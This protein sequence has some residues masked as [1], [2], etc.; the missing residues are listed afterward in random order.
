MLSLG[1]ARLID[2]HIR[3]IWSG[4][5]RIAKTRLM[6]VC[7]LMALSQG[8][9]RTANADPVPIKNRRRVTN[10]SLLI[11]VVT[12]RLAVSFALSLLSERK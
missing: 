8:G 6:S 9:L 11:A 1:D 3:V 4:K 2:R 10:G 7:A 12:C 5:M